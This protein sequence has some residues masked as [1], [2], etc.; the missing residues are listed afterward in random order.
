MSGSPVSGDRRGPSAA[1]PSAAILRGFVDQLVRAGLRDVVVCPGS[2]STP[3]ALAV[4]ADARLRL[5]THIDERAAAFFALGIAKATRLPAAVVTTSGTAAANLLPAVVEARYGRVPLLLLTAD[6]PPELRD[7]GSAQ[8][9]DQD[10]LFGRH[11][12]WFAELPVPESVRSGAEDGLGDPALEAIEAHWLG[13]ASRAV[14]VARE[15]PAGPVHL[16]LPFREPLVPDGPLAAAPELE[17]AAEAAGRAADPGA[18]FY[19]LMPPV[20]RMRSGA[21]EA[22]ARHFARV[23]R[24]LIIAGPLDEPGF[25]EAIVRLAAALDWPIAADPLSQVRTGPHDR[26]RVLSRADLVTRSAAFAERH[27]PD[28]VLRFGGLPTSKPLLALI[29]QARA[30]L[31]VDGGRGWDDPILR[32]ATVLHAHPTTLCHDVADALEAPGDALAPEGTPAPGPWASAWLHADLAVDIAVRRLIGALDEP[33]EG[34]L[35]TDIAELAPDGTILWAGSSMPVRDLDAHLA[36][37]PA[38]IRVLANR[39]ANGIDGVVSSALGAA[40]VHDGP[41]VLVVGDVS[42]LHDLNALVATRLNEAA[43]KARLTIVLVDNDGGGIFSFLP[44]ASAVDP[45]VGLPERFERLFGTPHGMGDAIGPIVEAFG[46]RYIA[47]EGGP[48]ALR[49]ILA[50]I[51]T[52]DAVSPADVGSGASGTTVVHLRTDRARNVALHREVATAAIA[53][54]DAAMAG[55]MTAAATDQ[56][57][58][59]LSR[60]SGEP[61][62]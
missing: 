52:A 23:E 3:I 19:A 21:V 49:E 15:T 4:A 8:T 51:L 42:F 5:W 43:A 7:R 58:M 47:V 39:G 28:L 36:G 13:V 45:G 31:I 29:A 62:R 55:A 17:P 34:S 60:H 2:R 26:R 22:L 37:T 6:R 32:P 27:T 33:F 10:H 44:Q 54:V 56:M 50:G 1:G 20:E 53:A 40:S 35:F 11:A 59:P 16:N 57:T 61:N 14:A 41:V 30:Q 38:A 18:P 46:A 12:K 24:G 9:I 48:G 25:P